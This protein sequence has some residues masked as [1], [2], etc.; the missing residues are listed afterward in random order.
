MLQKTLSKIESYLPSQY[1]E[2]VEH[3]S[4][5]SVLRL[6]QQLISFVS[7]FFIV[8]YV[9]QEIVGHYHF[10]LS[11][12][13]LV[14]ITSLP[15]MRTAV[16]QA[17]ARGQAGFF[18]VATRYCFLGSSLGSAILL[19][20]AAYHYIWLNDFIMAVAF[21]IAACLNPAAKGFMLWKTSYAGEERFKMLSVLN[22]VGTLITSSFLMLSVLFYTDSHV[23]LLAIALIVP[24]LQNL[25]LTAYEF[26]RHKSSTEAEDDLR[27]YGIKSSKYHILPVIAGEIDRISIYSFISA[28]ELALYNVAMKIP[29][30]FKT[31][32]RNLGTVIMPKL[33]RMP[34]YSQKLNRYFTMVSTV[35]LVLIVIFSFTILDEIFYWLTPPEY[36]SALIYAQA[37][38]FTFAV[39]NY[40]FLKG[41]YIYAQKN[42]ESNKK[43]S[44]ASNII[45][46][47]LM[48]V[49]VFFFQVWGAI[50]T[51]FA[52]RLFVSV[53]VNFIIKDHHT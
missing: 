12:V 17:M 42:I 30:I 31:L 44:I 34:S 1:K 19:V 22:T 41:R 25:I 46:I 28:S 4:Y 51:I 47:T 33:A 11:V 15:G 43:I 45:K 48:P 50:F 6:A 27:V 49:M 32:I 23:V 29:E 36:H 35:L 53:Y 5:V 14:S 3:F 10:V 21:V 2:I 37:L 39:G 24:A 20:I 38:L 18:K 13:A 40:G 8:K 26:Q 16:V 9:P 7:F 52:Q